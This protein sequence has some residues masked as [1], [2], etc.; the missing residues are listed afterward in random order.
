MTAINVFVIEN[1]EGKYLGSF[2]PVSGRATEWTQDIN[3]AKKW[4]TRERAEE[5]SEGIGQVRR[6]T[7]ATVQD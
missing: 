6:Y 2:D 1:W 4:R 5:M 7:V 3:V